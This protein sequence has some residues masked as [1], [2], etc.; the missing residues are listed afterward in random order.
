MSKEKVVTNKNNH[1]SLIGTVIPIAL[2][3]LFGAITTLI[4]ISIFSFVLIK[5]ELIS[6]IPI[7]SL[8]SLFIG[9]IVCGRF[10]AKFF[11]QNK[12]LTASICGFIIILI[13]FLLNTLIF[14]E[15]MTYITYI[16]YGFCILLCMV[17]TYTIKKN[18][19]IRRKH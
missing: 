10:N 11:S 7:F 6:L 14:K 16:K 8:V 4:F 3:I 17:S 12:V 13:M 9:C 5:N 18:K 19:K 15:N 1:F 2:C